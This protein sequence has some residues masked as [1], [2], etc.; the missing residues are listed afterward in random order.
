MNAVRAQERLAALTASSHADVAD[1]IVA[2][3]QAIASLAAE[4]R[5]EAYIMAYADGFYLVGVGPMLSLGAI[6]LLQKPG[7]VAVPTEAH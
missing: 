7:A 2:K 6:A 1:L 3:A 5:H 4:V